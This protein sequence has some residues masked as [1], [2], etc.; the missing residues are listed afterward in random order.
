MSIFMHVETQIS[1]LFFLSRY[2]LGEADFCMTSSP[3]SLFSTTAMM[4][5]GCQYIP[6][7]LGGNC[8]IE[9]DMARHKKPKN[10]IV[11]VNTF[12]IFYLRKSSFVS[13]TLSLHLKS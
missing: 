1:D 13:P 8:T 4:R 6:F 2:L 11:L 5:T 7:H 12:L 3:H 10:M 9:V